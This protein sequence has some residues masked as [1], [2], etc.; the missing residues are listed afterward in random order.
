MKILL[1]YGGKINSRVKVRVI[2]FSLEYVYY[3]NIRCKS[4]VIVKNLIE[5]GNF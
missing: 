1:K 4:K 3:V 5:K 2:G